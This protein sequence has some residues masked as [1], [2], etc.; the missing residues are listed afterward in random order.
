MNSNFD[1]LKN[2]WQQ[3]KSEP[4]EYNQLISKLKRMERK[5]KIERVLL[6]FLFPLTIIS[7][8]ILLPFTKSIYYIISISLLG[9]GMLMILFQMYQSRIK[10]NIKQDSLSNKEFVD[11][12][13]ITFNRKMK[14]TSR[15]LWVYTILLII[16][17]N[18]GYIEVLAEMILFHRI[19]VHFAISIVVTWFMYSA[20][21]KRIIKNKRENLPIIENLKKIQD[22][23]T[24]T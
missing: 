17:I 12:M 15:Y 19:L 22:E 1:D 9:I 24:N 7:L 10:H 18:I 4:V 3:V 21:N 16:G 2:I 11:K 13:I 20:I 8:M 14:I 23:L 5:S 6:V